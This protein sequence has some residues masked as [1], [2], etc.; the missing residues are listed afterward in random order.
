MLSNERFAKITNW[1][2]GGL[3]G[4]GTFVVSISLPTTITSHAHAKAHSQKNLSRKEAI[5]YVHIK[6]KELGIT[7]DINVNIYPDNWLL[8]RKL[9]A[10]ATRNEGL[11]VSYAIGLEKNLVREAYIDHELYHIYRGDVRA[12]VE[13]KEAIEA[14]VKLNEFEPKK[15]FFHRYNPIERWNKEVACD[16]YVLTV[17]RF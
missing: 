15:T 6:Q 13:Q 16:F 8:H 7:N 4:L 14:Y 3:V 5:E 2:I 9:A 17:W 12:P 11:D 10:C 1:I